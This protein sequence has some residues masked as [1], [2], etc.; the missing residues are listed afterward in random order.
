MSGFTQ[1]SCVELQMS[2][3]AVGRSSKTRVFCLHSTSKTIMF[4]FNFKV[5]EQAKEDHKDE[6]EVKKESA[7]EAAQ[8]VA[9]E[10]VFPEGFSAE[11][12]TSACTLF[13]SGDLE[14][15]I[16]DPVKVRNESA[17]ETHSDLIPGVYEGGF[18]VWECTQD[19]ADYLV[20]NLKGE[21]SGKEVLDLGCGAGLLGIVALKLGAAKCHFQDYNK[22]V[23]QKF[24]IPNILLNAEA[25][26]E[27]SIG[28]CQF[29]SGDWGSFTEATGDRKF[30]VILTSETI[31]NPENNQ[32][33]ID[34]F[35][36]KLRRGGKVLLAAKTYYFG[37]G[38]GLRQ[39]EGMTKGR[40]ACASVWRNCEGVSREIIKIEHM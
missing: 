24:T 20:E 1:T 28:K 19:L 14:I 40:M 18:K 9:C 37:V 2:Q 26:G 34:L 7:K 5:E 21:L 6:D 15:P 22:D 35:V 39:F 10:E 23:L 13:I 31:Y 25:D 3:K 32:K 27:V 36:G 8:V 38:G 11:E 12:D 29:Y 30:D 4:Q 17:E 33:V 16:L